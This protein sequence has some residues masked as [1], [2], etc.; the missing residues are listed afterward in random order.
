MT[1]YPDK[2]KQR[3]Y[4]KHQ[5]KQRR[6]SLKRFWLGVFVAF[7][8]GYVLAYVYQPTLLTTWVQAYV[9]GHEASS[10]S[11]HGI[12][13]SQRLKPKLEF[14]TLLTQEK[15]TPNKSKPLKVVPPRVPVQAAAAK[16]VQASEPKRVYMLQL[17]SFQ[18]REDAEHM[19]ASLIMR[20]IDATLKTVTQQGVAWHRVMMGPFA[21]QSEAEKA[22]GSI[23]RSERISGMIR[24]M[25]V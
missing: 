22:Q 3:P 4:V 2:N 16:P 23:A 10:V 24:R 12:K 21:S 25:D 7:V 6:Q 5:V 15:A 14:Y 20:G 8:G 9:G 13:S 11:E 19:Q 18:R 17:A 1:T